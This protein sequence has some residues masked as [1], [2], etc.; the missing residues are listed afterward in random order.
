MKNTPNPYL[1][2][3]LDIVHN[4]RL[5]W[6]LFRDKRVPLWTKG[7]P[8]AAL[9]Y[10]VWPLDI[11]ADPALGLGQLDDLAIIMLGIKAFVSLCPPQLV[12]QLR[13]QIMTG[14]PHVEHSGPVVDVTYRVVTNDDRNSD[15]QATR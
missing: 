15:D 10:L 3:I 6:Q 12:A 13:Q 5:A 8:L 9:A 1:A 11:L 14:Q 7:V 2:T 4:L